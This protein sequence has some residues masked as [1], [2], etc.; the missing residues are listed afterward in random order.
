[1]VGGDGSAGVEPNGEAGTPVAVDDDRVQ[2]EGGLP[3]GLAGLALVVGCLLPGDDPHGEVGGVGAAFQMHLPRS[4]ADL[5]DPVGD[6][7]AAVFLEIQ[8][9]ATFDVEAGEVDLG[10]VD[11]VL[12]GLG[13]LVD[14]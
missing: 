9:D 10:V 1:M 5:G 6:L 2:V 12:D 14:Q 4:A 3:A 13:E 7:F 8:V 11:P